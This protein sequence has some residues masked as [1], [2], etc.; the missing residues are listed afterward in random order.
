MPIRKL[1]GHHGTSRQ[2]AETILSEGFAASQNSYDWLGDGA[3]FW[4]DAPLRAMEWA[5]QIFAE[6]AVVIEATIEIRDFINLLDVEWMS[7][8]TE[9]YD[10]YLEEL[11][12]S[13]QPPPVQS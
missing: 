3:Y 1:I 7:W 9:I 6:D 13:G 8:L 2:I 11:K 4:Q 5:K 12:R 10:E